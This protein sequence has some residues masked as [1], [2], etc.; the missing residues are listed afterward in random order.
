MDSEKFNDMQLVKRRMFAMRNGIVADALR[1]GGSPFRVVFGVNLPQLKEIAADTGTN[2]SLARALY[3][4]AGTRES[5][6]IAP[7]LMPPEAMTTDLAIEWLGQAPC[8]EVSDILCH[9]L[10]KKLPNALEIARRA[11]ASEEPMLRYG[12][13]RLAWN[14]LPVAGGVLRPDIEK[15][16]ARGDRLTQRPA[17]SFLEEYDFL[18]AL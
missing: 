1:T 13:V 18:S 8:V 4:D 12:G 17:Q 16:A 11:L 3:A 2:E 15:E 14:L 7:M 5:M 10:L 9:S 6:L